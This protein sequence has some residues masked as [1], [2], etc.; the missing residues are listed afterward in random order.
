VRPFHLALCLPL[1][2]SCSTLDAGGDGQQDAVDVD[3]PLVF[4]EQLDPASFDALHRDVIRPSCASVEAFCHHGQFEPNLTTPAL[5]YNSLVRRPGIELF[6]RHR[7]T[8]GDPAGSLL[9]DKLRDRAGVATLMPLGAPPM[10][11]GD[12]QRIE[13]WIEDGALRRPAA[14]PAPVLNDPPLPPELAVFDD[15]GQR[16]DDPGMAV[17][18]VGQTVTLR[19]S[20]QDFETPDAAVPYGA[21]FLQLGDGRSV[22]LDPAYPGGATITTYDAAGPEGVTDQLNWRSDWTVPDMLPVTLDGGLAED[23]PAAGQ[24]LLM[25]GLYV[26][27]DPANGG[28]LGFSFAIDKIFIVGGAP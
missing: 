7:V 19:H 5:A 23:V 3:D 21:V 16:L 17:V 26:D 1:L 27:G 12:I 13:Q 15:T 8:P 18:A 25:I 10:P 28:I 20:V 4:E 22:V 24:S 11:E 6:D 14:E 2:M 9:I